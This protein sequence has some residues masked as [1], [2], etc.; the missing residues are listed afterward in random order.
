M[1]ELSDFVFLFPCLPQTMF[2]VSSPMPLKLVASLRAEIGAEVRREQAEAEEKR[3]RMVEEREQRRRERE[4][5]KGN[6]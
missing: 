4:E 6:N 2:E 1:E 3:K 5:A